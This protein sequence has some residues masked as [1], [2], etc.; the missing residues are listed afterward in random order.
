MVCYDRLLL[1]HS[2]NFIKLTF[3][4]VKIFLVRSF[5]ALSSAAPGGSCP[6]LPLPL[7]TPLLETYKAETCRDGSSFYRPDVLRVCCQ[8]NSVIKYWLYVNVR[9]LRRRTKSYCC[10]KVYMVS[11][12]VRMCVFSIS[13]YVCAL[14]NGPTRSDCQ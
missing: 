3:V 4:V 1:A 11:Y 13:I 7:V 2:T 10:F 14:F 12:C 6:T 9:F 8:T 5:C